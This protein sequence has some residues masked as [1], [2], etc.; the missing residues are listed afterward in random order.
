[1][2]KILDSLVNVPLIIPTVALGF[3]LSLFWGSIYAGDSLGL[4]M[5]I[6][7]H[8]SF[9]FPLVVRNIVGAVE[10]VDSSYEEVAMT[11]GAK[12]FQA[13]SKVLMPIIQS[14]I[15]AGAILAFTRSLGETGATIAI[16]D[17]VNTVPVYIMSLIDAHNYTEAAFC[18]IILIAICFV[19]MFALRI[20]ISRGGGRRA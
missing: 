4:F 14:S 11:L 18:S 3:S 9:T 19:F 13:F 5:V 10:E 7:G 6:L 2:G 12:P 17:K 1:L 8:I 15:I 16:S 20:V